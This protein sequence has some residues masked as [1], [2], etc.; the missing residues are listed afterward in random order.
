MNQIYKDNP[1]AILCYWLIKYTSNSIFLTGKAGTGKSTFLR[2]LIE[3]FPNKKVVV[4]APTG[5]AALN[6][7]GQTIH[8]FFKFGPRP[9]LPNDSK[10]AIIEGKREL[11]KN[12]DIVIIDE[13]SMVRADLFAAI[14]TALQRY[15]EN[16]LPF[17]GKQMLFIGDLFQLP[18]VTDSNNTGDLEIMRK[19]YNSMYFF[20]A[21]IP[22]FSYHIIELDKVYRQENDANFLSILN[23]IRED[24][25]LSQQIKQLND[26]V[27]LS[28]I[29]NEVT[30][31]TTNA[32]A[33]NINASK[34][35]QITSK[36]YF[37][38]ANVTG[39][40]EREDNES[41]IPA[42]IILSLKVGAQVMFLKN[43]TAR[44]W[45]NGTIGKVANLSD[46]EIIV[47]VDG[48]L[49]NV[50]KF[51]W[52][53]RLYNWN[54]DKHEI[55]TEI[56]GT[57]EQYPLRL[58]WAMTIHKSQGKT[59]D[60][61]IVN[62]GRGAFEKGQTYVALSRCRTLEGL[63]LTKAITQ[64]DIIVS[65]EV[66]QFTQKARDISNGDA[67]I[68]VIQKLESDMAFLYEE[69]YGFNTVLTGFENE[70]FKAEINF[71]E[72]KREVK[73]LKLEVSEQYKNILDIKN[74]N[75][76][77][78][79]EL[80]N[81]NTA[82][83]RELTE[84]SQDIIKLNDVSSNKLKESNLSLEKLKQKLMIKN[85]ILW[86]IILICLILLSKI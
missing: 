40:F 45:V 35:S 83:K 80:S 34:L 13:I 84:R 22:N 39:A 50:S 23:S 75:S 54:R 76:R 7:G 78:I 20:G 12:I 38:K 26:R 15:C 68:S 49:F 72:V 63:V 85:T 55:E 53:S 52:E 4:L 37:Y 5:V 58:A 19:N 21:S 3:Q 65:E 41:K 11:M 18:P 10:I 6:V 42:A 9:Y 86:F 25:V 69:I 56:I 71:E 33:D 62:L 46:N 73:N 77:K 31:C 51:L 36:E 32:I 64:N 74:K 57:F 2:N 29:G 30:L 66:K 27:G 48:A 79:I 17:G 67:F 44:R 8:S 28:L 60:N 43:D 47:D 59:F 24:S 61:I 14:N 16:N 1:Q 82:L 81:I 70:L